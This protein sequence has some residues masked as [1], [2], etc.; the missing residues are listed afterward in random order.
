MPRLRDTVS[1][2]RSAAHTDEALGRFLAELRDKDGTS[3]MRLRVPM[4]VNGQAGA[5]LCVDREVRIEAKKSD[6]S[7][8]AGAIA[9]SWAPEGPLVFP[10]FDGTLTFWGDDD[11]SCVE[12]DGCYTPPFGNAGQ[13]FDATVGYEL[14]RATAR[15]FLT[16]VKQAIETG[17]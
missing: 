13:I 15:E 14:A 1:I 4:Q 7:K 17:S 9:I 12:L 2:D 11:K 16:D 6:A 5:G 3:R 8:L 10:T